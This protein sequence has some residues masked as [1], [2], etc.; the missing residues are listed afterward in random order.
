MIAEPPVAPAVNVTVAPPDVAVA[1]NEVGG[2]GVVAGVTDNASDGAPSPL[3]ST[4]RSRTVTAVPLVSPVI[5]NGDT[6]DEGD[7][8]VQ[9]APLSFEYL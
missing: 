2:E 4:A 6:V 3:A 8:V 7:R 1:D 5:C 9:F